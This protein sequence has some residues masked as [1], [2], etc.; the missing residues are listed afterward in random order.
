VQHNE[1]HGNQ[2][3]WHFHTHVFPRYEND[4]IY[5]SRTRETTQEERLHYARLLRDAIR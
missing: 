5:R 1:P 3:V 4:D 2:H